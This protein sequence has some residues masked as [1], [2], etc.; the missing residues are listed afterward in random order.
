M[1]ARPLWAVL[2]V[3]PF[4]DAKS[5]LAPVM[6]AGQRRDLAR[7]LMLHSLATLQGCA[8]V[9]HALVVSS[10]SEARDLAAAQGAEALDESGAGLNPALEEARSY[11][12]SHG[13][14]SLLVL[15]SDLPLLTASDLDAML[16]HDGPG[17]AIAPDHRR[18]GTN[19]LLLQPP[20]AIDFHFGESSLQQHH[21]AA[22]A[23]GI[24][25]I[26]VFRTGL[27]FDVDLPRDWHDLMSSGREGLPDLPLVWSRS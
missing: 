24:A 4:N 6:E 8:Q 18:Q 7:A 27:A 1:A 3:K 16:S 22:A 21:E 20:G 13:A 10:D 14:A 11:A 23:A 17:V 19:A 5:R 26:E 25:P 15:A 12:V 2:P 9:D